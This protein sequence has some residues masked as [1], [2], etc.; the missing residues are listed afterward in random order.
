VCPVCFVTVNM[1]TVDVCARVG[2][3][4][5]A[6]WCV[7]SLC[8]CVGVGSGCVVVISVCIAV[9][10]VRCVATNAATHVL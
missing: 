4:D 9:I 5:F 10:R 1:C 3:L 2:V 6:R 7:E 8:E